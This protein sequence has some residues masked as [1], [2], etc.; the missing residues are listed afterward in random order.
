MTDYD[1]DGHD[2]DTDTNASN[3]VSRNIWNLDNRKQF[4]VQTIGIL[5]SDV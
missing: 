5:S 4:T 3:N 1:S 2:T